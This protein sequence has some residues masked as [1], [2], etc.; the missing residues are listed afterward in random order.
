MPQLEGT[1]ID[2]FRIEVFH[3]GEEAE[4]GPRISLAHPE[5]SQIRP[6]AQQFQHPLPRRGKGSAGAAAEGVPFLPERGRADRSFS[7]GDM[8][9]V[10]AELRLVIGLLDK[11]RRSA[12]LLQPRFQI[13]RR[14]AH[15]DEAPHE[16]IRRE[17][18]V[19]ADKQCFHYFTSSL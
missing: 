3:A 18:A 8:E 15:V 17:H 6:A 12:C 2:R 9:I 7:A 5:R 14:H 19:A 4:K 1:G 11:N 13:R 16:H 10:R